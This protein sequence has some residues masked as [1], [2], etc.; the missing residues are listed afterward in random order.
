MAYMWWVIIFLRASAAVAWI[1]EHI[2][3]LFL[4][5]LSFIYLRSGKWKGRKI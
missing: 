4:M 5:T 2:Y 1:T 3:W